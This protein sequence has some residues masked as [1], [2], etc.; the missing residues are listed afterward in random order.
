M[1]DFDRGRGPPHHAGRGRTA[2]VHPV[3]EVQRQAEVF[4]QRGRCEHVRLRDAVA[5]QP[6]HH[7]RDPR[8]ASSITIFASRAYWSRVN[9]GGPALAAFGRQLRDADDGGLAAQPG[10]D[11][12]PLR[13]R[14]G[15]GARHQHVVAAPA[16]DVEIDQTR[17]TAC[18]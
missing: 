8:P 1:P 6:V 12:A 2:Q 13:Q 4:R 15:R 3:T 11:V 16:E 9:D 5:R 17:R 7:S 18:R 10:H 14:D